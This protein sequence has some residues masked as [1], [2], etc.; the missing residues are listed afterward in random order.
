[1]SDRNPNGPRSGRLSGKT[2]IV[3]GGTKGIGESIVRQFAAA[4]ARQVIV[5]RGAVDGERLV[6]AFGADRIRFVRGDVADPTT[7]AHAVQACV[8]AFGSPSILVNNAALDFAAELFTPSL[9]DVRRVFDANFN[10]AW[11]F[12]IACARQMTNGGSIVNIT[13]RTAS[14]GVP[15]MSVYGASKG[16]LLSFTRCAAIELA[17]IG[18]RVNAVAPGPT[19]T[20]LIR[21]WI[22]AQS[23]PAEFE[24]SVV[25]SIPQKRL[26]TSDEVAAAVLFL[27]SDESSHITGA[28]LAVDGGFTAA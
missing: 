20:P 10:G 8:E 15:T 21:A 22:D 1:L 24:E 25:A 27:A 2:A 4:G 5:A 6:R 28:S 17:P 14:V 3:T 11:L 16:A 12:T 18:I 26:A 7:A 23:R 19:D 13:S 9:E